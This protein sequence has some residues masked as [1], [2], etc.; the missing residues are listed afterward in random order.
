MRFKA[1]IIILGIL[2]FCEIMFYNYVRDNNIK[3]LDHKITAMEHNITQI[4]SDRLN[5]INQKKKLV[6]IIQS[7]PSTILVGFEDP[8]TKFLEFLDYLHASDLYDMEGTM[9]LLDTQTFR[10]R[11]VPLHESNF[12]F[13]FHF[14]EIDEA[15]NFFTYLLLQKEYPFQVKKLEITRVEENKTRVE[16]SMA[17]LIPARMPLPLLS[18]LTGKNTK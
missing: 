7:I 10:E 13:N 14:S 1:I 4:E 6:S 16:L 12:Q 15:E 2:F 18:S 3:E 11:P 9:S 17:L 8:E 5:L